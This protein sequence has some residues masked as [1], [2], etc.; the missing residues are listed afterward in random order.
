MS[1]DVRTSSHGPLTPANAYL[2]NEDALRKAFDAEYGSSIESARA[3]LG[4]AQVLA[5]R[6]VETAF[7]NVWQQRAT[8]ATHEQFKKVLQDEVHHGA[9]RALSRRIA[10]HRFNNSG[11]DEK[12]M[13]GTHQ[14]TGEASPEQSWS[15]ITRT[16][17]GEGDTAAA[18][19]QVASASRH[20]AAAHM[21]DVAK[22]R[23]W[24]VPI[25]I[26][27]VALAASIGGVM[28]IDRLGED[29][30]M[31]AAV[32]NPSIQPV[33]T[34]PGQLGNT[35]LGDGTATR[36][37][38]A[39]KL[40]IA[41]HFGT[42]LRALKLDGTAL[43]DVA[44]DEKLPFRV[45]AYR[46][47]VI[48][49]GTSFAVSTFGPESTVAVMVKE[50]TVQVKDGKASQSVSANQTV[51]AD[52]K[53]IRAATPDEQQSYFSW[54]DGR[55]GAKGRLRDVVDAL[56]RWFGAD[57]KIPDMK[58]IDRPASFEASLDSMKAAVTQIEQSAQVHYVNAGQENVFED[59]A[60]AK[61]APAPKKKK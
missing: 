57:A 58:L 18:H 35:K 55:V 22:G 49:T 44:K 19:K 40:M 4:D 13:T 56:N 12:S 14:A 24:T 37:G 17:R 47:H 15:Q 54:L 46:T 59:A 34:S 7:I 10:A 21:K 45:I 48:A 50:G 52:P 38:P 61:A 9:A 29:D 11:R 32:N 20:E 30:A 16:I 42:Q 28:Y 53:G 2:N 8:I 43:F 39:T 23:N 41:D 27:V 51:I 36:I 3:Q 60:G 1:T 25:L 26:G 31:F 6:V 33:Q 5:P